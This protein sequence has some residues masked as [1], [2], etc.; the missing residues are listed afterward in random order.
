LPFSGVSRFSYRGRK[1][2]E[3]KTIEEEEV[4]EWKQKI[5]IATARRRFSMPWWAQ[6]IVECQ[7]QMPGPAERDRFLASLNDILPRHKK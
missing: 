5:F 7:C 4:K 2:K 3:I 6:L 1:K